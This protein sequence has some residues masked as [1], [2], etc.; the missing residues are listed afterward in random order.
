MHSGFSLQV[1]QMTSPASLF[2][3]FKL[4]EDFIQKDPHKTSLNQASRT[5]GQRELLLQQK[6]RD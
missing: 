3:F 5:K 6:E 2:F 1:V 4:N